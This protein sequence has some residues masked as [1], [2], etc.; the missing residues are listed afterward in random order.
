VHVT[1][2]TEPAGTEPKLTLHLPA[3][4]P[5]PK[6]LLTQLENFSATAVTLTVSQAGHTVQLPITTILFFQAEGHQVRAHTRESSYQTSWHLYELAAQLPAT[7]LRISKSAIAN[8]QLITSLT[9]SLTG[10]LV[11]FENSH[12]QLYA[13]RRYYRELKQT[14]EKESFK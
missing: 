7:F 4:Y 9:K 14:L 3:D 2:K 11:E 13:S 1:V 10:N 12:K 5:N 6:Q 8:T